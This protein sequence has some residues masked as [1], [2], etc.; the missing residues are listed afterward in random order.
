MQGGR[1]KLQFPTSAIARKRLKIDGYMLLCVWPA[2]NPLS[3]HVTFTAIVPYYRYPGDAKMCKKS[4]LATYVYL[5]TT[6]VEAAQWKD[7][8]EDR[9]THRQTD[10]IAI[11][12]IAQAQ[13]STVIIN[14]YKTEIHNITISSS[15]RIV[16]SVIKN[17]NTAQTLCSID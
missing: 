17:G 10:M 12:S 3:I 7:R 2:L 4:R 11:L 5:F 13:Q 6:K 14:T 1:E 8:Q 9:K 16:D 15:K